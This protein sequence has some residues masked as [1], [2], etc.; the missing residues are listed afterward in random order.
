ML[1]YI[2]SLSVLFMLAF[3][4][5]NAT[6]VETVPGKLAETLAGFSDID[7][8]LIV[9]GSINATDF[10][11]FEN[12]KISRLDLSQV[13]IAE[14]PATRAASKGLKY[15]AAN[16]LPQYCFFA[17]GCNELILPLSLTAI[18]DG[19]FAN[20]AVS[21]IV[22]PAGVV[23]IGNFAF[24]NCDGLTDV[25]IPSSVGHIGREAF[26]KCSGLVS[27]DLSSSRLK[28]LPERLFADCPA[29]SKLSLPSSV[30]EIQREAL[31]GSGIVSIDLSAVYRIGDYA[32]ACS[33]NLKIVTLNPDGEF[34][35]GILM[36]CRSLTEING[37][38]ADVPDLFVA[39]CGSINPSSY[40]EAIES[41]GKYSFANSELST[42][43]LSKGLDFI[44]RGAFANSSALTLIEAL[45]LKSDCPDV[46]DDAFI[47]LDTSRI[48]LH[49]DSSHEQAW[50]THPVWSM[51]DIFSDTY[52][53]IMTPTADTAIRISVENG[54][55]HVA[56]P[57]IIN[58]VEL[59]SI[60]G[61]R[62][63][64]ITP[65][66]TEISES[67]T[68]LNT[69]GGIVVIRVSTDSNSRTAKIIF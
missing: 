38:P 55:L 53:D 64:N 59:F 3:S 57:E 7:T 65:R 18:C 39:N 21:R 52:D 4:Q 37:I 48:R 54:I 33:P 47:G 63:A 49:V 30:S 15:S 20:S 11:A 17:S 35:S 14:L 50:L 8:E 68:D 36:N 58:S 66:E 40:S 45:G 23:S 67:L 26:G 44:D 24:Y 62:L 46:D 41:V 28:S 42:L 25:A 29:L 60:D 27:A 2:F 34:G 56:A 9:T 32:L 6:V 16:E 1:R 5:G 69:D 61:I 43:I 13:S 10:E 19:A 31:T 22:I 12:L 51:F